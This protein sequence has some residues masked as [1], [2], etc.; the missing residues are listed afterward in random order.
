MLPLLTKE[1]R[2]TVIKTVPILPR[3]T[4]KS[5]SVQHKTQGFQ[6]MVP[7]EHLGNHQL[8]SEEHL[9]LTFP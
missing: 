2:E 7:R 3:C 4:Q 5:V 1:A 6:V 8:N 9:F